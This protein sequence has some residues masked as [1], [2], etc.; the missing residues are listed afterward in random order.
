MQ[1]ALK[2]AQSSQVQSICHFDVER[3][4]FFG[5]TISHEVRDVAS[6]KRIE[7]DVSIVTSFGRVLAFSASWVLLSRSYFRP[8]DD[9]PVVVFLFLI[10]SDGLARRRQ[11]RSP[12]EAIQS[13]LGHFYANREDLSK[14]R[15]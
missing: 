9:S 11:S 4:L 14:A 10:F 12:Y 6:F 7:Q 8:A 13:T 2:F 1:D 5:D 3:I 15:H